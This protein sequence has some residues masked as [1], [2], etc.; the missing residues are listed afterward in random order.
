MKYLAVVAEGAGTEL[1]L[2]DLMLVL[3]VLMEVDKVVLVLAL[4]VVVAETVTG[5]VLV[6]TTTAEVGFGTHWSGSWS[7]M[8]TV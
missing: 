1:E 3:E 8:V 4:L 6:V 5:L 2:V 7:V